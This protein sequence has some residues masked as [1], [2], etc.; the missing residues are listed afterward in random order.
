VKSRKGDKELEE[1][2]HR[3]AGCCLTGNVSDQVLFFFYGTGANER[4]IYTET[5]QNIQGD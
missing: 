5:M 1:Y 2:M 3:A 4:S